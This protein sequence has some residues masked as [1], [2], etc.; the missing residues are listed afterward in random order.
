[1]YYYAKQDKD[2]HVVTQVFFSEKFGIEVSETPAEIDA[3][4]K[5]QHP[6]ELI[7]AGQNI[8]A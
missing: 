8:N 6:V 7:D 3:L 1:M 5:N 2:G 4:I